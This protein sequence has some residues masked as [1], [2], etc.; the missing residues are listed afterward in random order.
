M[1][2]GLCLLAFIVGCLFGYKYGSKEI[3]AAK[4]AAADFAKKL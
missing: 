3:K 4:T 1:L 2:I